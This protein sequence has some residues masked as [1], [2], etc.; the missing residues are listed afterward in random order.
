MTPECARKPG[1]VV[2]PVGAELKLFVVLNKDAKWCIWCSEA[3]RRETPTTSRSCKARSPT[4]R[5]IW[6]EFC[7][8]RGGEPPYLPHAGDPV[9]W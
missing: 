7:D 2:P 6:D 8:A 4:R 3:L 1:V 5:G 9:R